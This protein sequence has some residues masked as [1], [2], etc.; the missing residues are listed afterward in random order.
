MGARQRPAFFYVHARAT[1]GHPMPI[2]LAE[3]VR[4]RDN[5][6]NVIRLMAAFAVLVTHSF[7]MTTGS[8]PLR[9]SLGLTWGVI[10]VN[11]FF[12]TSGFLVTSSLLGRNSALDFIWARVLRIYPALWLMLAL[13]VLGLG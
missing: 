11:V 5:N 1:R 4:G 3:L 12:L 8:E 13:T 6:F 7:G 9:S 2:A 10:A